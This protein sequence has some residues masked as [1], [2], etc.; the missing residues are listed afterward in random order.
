MP[1]NSSSRYQVP[2]HLQE[3]I[4]YITPG[5]KLSV[6]IS[7]S[8]RL[9]RDELGQLSGS[10]SAGFKS[11]SA[12]IN[13]VDPLS[14]CDVVM[15]PQCI[16]ALYKIPPGGKYISG[17]NLGIYERGDFVSNTSLDLFFANFTNI[18]QGTRPTRINIDG[19]SNFTSS[20]SD[21]HGEADLDFQLAYPIVYPQNITQFQTDDLYYSGY[22]SNMYDGLFN[23]FLDALDGV[24]N[25]CPYRPIF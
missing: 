5:I 24:S 25:H 4:D 14:S 3:H 18:P 9:R 1:N 22:G 16:A 8:G 12:S 13:S 23:T 11:A 6:P 15:T 7:R 17:N 20:E 21:S 2:Q 10:R 19:L